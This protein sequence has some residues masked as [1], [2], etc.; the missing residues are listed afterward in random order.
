[1]VIITHAMNDQQLAE[2][3]TAIAGQTDMH[4]LASYKVLKNE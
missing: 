4:L 2:I 3:T 1:V